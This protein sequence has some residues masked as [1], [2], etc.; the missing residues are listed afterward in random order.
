MTNLLL[1]MEYKEVEAEGKEIEVEGR[2]E[3]EGYGVEGSIKAEEKKTEKVEKK[4]QLV[5]GEIEGS[6]KK[7]KGTC[8]QIMESM[9]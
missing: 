8:M 9:E 7:S 3:I 6:G 5:S 4:G 2:V 1:V